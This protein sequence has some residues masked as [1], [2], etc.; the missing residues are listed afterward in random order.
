MIAATLDGDAEQV[1][2]ARLAELAVR[3]DDDDLVPLEVAESGSARLRVRSG[4]R[5]VVEP[6][7]LAAPAHAVAA[8]EITPHPVAAPLG[9]VRALDRRPARERRQLDSVGSE[10]GGA[11]GLKADSAFHGARACG[12][13]LARVPNR[14]GN[15]RRKRVD[16]G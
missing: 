4:S 10:A 6:R 14:S 3:P 7:P 15:E 11:L 12:H 13:D 8:S 1:S 9:V 16:E 5:G 2:V